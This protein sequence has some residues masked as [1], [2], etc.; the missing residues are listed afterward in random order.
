MKRLF[1]VLAAVLM[2]ALLA[3][4]AFAA[5]EFVPSIGYKD[6]PEIEEVNP[7]PKDENPEN[8]PPKESGNC[9]VIT[10]I[11]QAQNKE[12]DISQEER[13]T[14]LDIYASLKNNDMTMPEI[15]DGLVIR[16]L[17]DV[18]WKYDHC[19]EADHGK[20]EWLEKEGNALT[21]TLQ[22]NM[23]ASVRVT[24]LLYVDG[25]WRE[26]EDVTNNGDGTITCTF[27]EIGPVAICVPGDANE[28]P[29]VTGDNLGRMLWLWVLLLVCSMAALTTLF[30]SR[31]KFLR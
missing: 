7:V 5:N 28:P 30:L 3:V 25:V 20:D 24:V 23:P 8:A 11:T 31:R 6:G 2:M 29:A 10:T 19:V 1:A 27:D 4:P 14:L 26:V 21:V 16:E 17:V 15:A 12:T 22:T 13:D 18:S 9:L